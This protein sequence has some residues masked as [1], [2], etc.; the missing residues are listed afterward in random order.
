MLKLRR[1]HLCPAEFFLAVSLVPYTGPERVPAVGPIGVHTPVRPAD[2][3]T[4]R[5]P[6]RYFP[7]DMN[8]E[9]ID[10]KESP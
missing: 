6:G 9:N 3:D 10:R 1:A 2:G 8:P 5:E 7:P 4:L